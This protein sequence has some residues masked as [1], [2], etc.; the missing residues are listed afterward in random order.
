[1]KNK[2]LAAIAAAL[3]ALIIIL[4]LIYF[5]LPA[6]KQAEVNSFEECA[7]AGFP[8]QES[9]PRRCI[10]GTKSFVEEISPGFKNDKIEV[11][12]PVLNAEVTTPLTVTGRARGTWFFEASFPVKLLDGNGSVIAQTP[13][14]AK[15]EWMTTDFVPYEAQLQF[16]DPVTATGT[17]VLE[18]DDPSG[19]PQN[20][21]EVRIPVRFI[22]YGH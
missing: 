9:Y 5:L 17:L 7:A 3:L 12:A 14:Q 8:I 6:K 22:Q 18:K 4:I 16:Q 13:A 15:G 2:A 1:M 19:L 10:A 20:A 21:D 11:D